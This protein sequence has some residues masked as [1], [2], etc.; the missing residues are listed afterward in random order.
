MRSDLLLSLAS[1][2]L[3]GDQ[4]HARRALRAIAAEESQKRHG[5]VADK[6]GFLLDTAPLARSTR[7]QRGSLGDTSAPSELI[8]GTHARVANKS[9]D[10]VTLTTE[11]R[12]LIAELLEE[13]RFRRELR[14]SGLEPRSRVLLTG[15]PGTGKTSLAEAIATE[16]AVPLYVLQYE[17]VIASFLGD[18]SSKL[19]QV[20][21][22]ASAEQC[23]LFFDEFETLAKERGDDHD[24]GEVKRVVSTLLLQIDAL[25]SHVVVIGATNHPELLDRAAWRRFQI[26]IEMP[27][28]S[29]QEA[30]FWAKELS[31]RLNI[32]WSASLAQAVAEVGQPSYAAIEEIV[33]SAKRK[34]VI[35]TA[36][37]YAATHQP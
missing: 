26:Q 31:Q 6:I 29:S 1:A 25:P 33:V 2:A 34:Q 18:T 30:L 3:D 21:Q 36:K 37:Q 20:F 4:Q 23:V 24:T 16:L 9:L 12:H 11:A 35:Q 27:L 15:A 14:S 8:P 10:A 7:E 5:R 22:R 13:Q 19:S 17:T 32:R 28:P